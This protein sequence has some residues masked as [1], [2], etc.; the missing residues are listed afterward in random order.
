[1]K[2]KESK[3]FLKEFPVDNFVRT[4]LTWWDGGGKR[5][6]PWRRTSDPYRILISEIMLHRTNANQVVP[7]F[8]SFVDKYP[9]ISSIENSSE[10]DIHQLLR[11]L[12]LYWRTTLIKSMAIM[13][14]KKYSGKIPYA[15]KELVELPGISNYIASAIRCF[16]FGNREVLL[17]TN[18]VRIIGRIFGLKV[19]DTS[20]RSKLFRDIL[21]GM[22][23]NNKSREFNYALIDFASKICRPVPLD[24]ICPLTSLCSFISPIRKI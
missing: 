13:I 1:M 21:D 10:T 16:A 7:I 12:G 17:D 3:E 14:M 6:F 2:I 24:S 23:P 18:T 9:D 15:Y 5:D 11:P 22:M 19:D 8:N 4:L 20:R